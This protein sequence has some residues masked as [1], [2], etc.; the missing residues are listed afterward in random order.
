MSATAA[1]SA[2]TIA[3]FADPSGDDYVALTA[4]LAIVTGVVALIPGCCGWASWRASSGTGPQGVRR[5]SALTII[6]GQPPKLFGVDDASGNFFERLWG[7][8]TSLGETD[9]PTFVVGFVS[10]ALVLG[11]RRYLHLVPGS[12]VAVALGVIVVMLFHLDQKGVEVVGTITPGLP[13]LGLPGG[14][15]L[16]QYLSL[17]AR[18][19][20][21]S[22]SGSPTASG[23]P[24]RHRPGPRRAG[25]R[26]RRHRRH[27]GVPQRVGRGRCG[28]G[29]SAQRHGIDRVTVFG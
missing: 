29:G 20:A 6:M 25:P 18:P 23:R 19:A 16:D 3:T 14:V 27:D 17:A 9:W 22:S 10:L 12:L 2:G 24:R 26:R 1:L 4:A 5:R 8:V 21:W 15:G 7:L 28:P 13:H 11:L